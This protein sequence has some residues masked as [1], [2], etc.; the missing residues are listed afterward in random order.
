[1][2][3]NKLINERGFDEASAMRFLKSAVAFGDFSALQ[4][5]IAWCGWQEQILRKAIP[6]LPV[7][8][9]LLLMWHMEHSVN[10]RAN[11]T[12]SAVDLLLS[13]RRHPH[14]R[15]RDVIY[16]IRICSLCWF[17]QNP[18][19]SY[20]FWCLFFFGSLWFQPVVFGASRSRLGWWTAW[21]PWTC[22]TT[23]PA[24]PPWNPRRVRVGLF[25]RDLRIFRMW[26]D[27]NNLF[28]WWWWW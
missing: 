2:L 4:L 12:Q 8:S 21:W 13:I 22:G 11:Q 20:G 9:A 6:F 5:C 28:L 18:S 17:D 10:F 7:P 26:W 19:K 1:M 24:K 23:C 25:F 16:L 14:I 15:I 27:N 3:L